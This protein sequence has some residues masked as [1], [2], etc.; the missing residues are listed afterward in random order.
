MTAVGVCKEQDRIEE[1][2][3]EVKSKLKVCECE[4]VC[5][6]VQRKEGAAKRPT[7]ET[8]IRRRG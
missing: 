6:C 3:R 2:R 8:R 5:V 4:Y 7:K 1:E